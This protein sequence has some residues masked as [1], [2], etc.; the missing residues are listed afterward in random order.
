MKIRWTKE[1]LTRLLEVETYI[2]EDNPAVAIDFVDS[3]IS[4][5]EKI[6]E[7]PERG[8]VVPELSVKSIREVIYKNYRIVYILQEES[9][10]ILTVFESHRKLRDNEI[11]QE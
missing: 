11:N 9:I 5:A 6:A 4:Y 1:A 2:A 8:R 7:N 3:L 10:D